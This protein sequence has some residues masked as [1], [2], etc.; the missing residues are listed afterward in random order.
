MRIRF[1]ITLVAALLICTAAQAVSVSVE[2]NTVET[3][4]NRCHITFVVENKARETLESLKLDLAV[5]NLQRIVQ[6][7]LATE[8]GPVRG[9]KTIVKTFALDGACGEIGSI[10]VN[11]VSCAPGKAEECLDGLSLTSRITAVRLYK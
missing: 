5:F 8:L 2:L 4:D 7:R 3:A 9:A 1:S 10:L 6:R 11:D